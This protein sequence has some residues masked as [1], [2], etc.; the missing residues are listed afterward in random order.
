[1][2]DSHSTSRTSCGTTNGPQPDVCCSTSQ[3]RLVQEAPPG[4]LVHRPSGSVSQSD[5]Q[6]R[7]WLPSGSLQLPSMSTMQGG[8]QSP[9][10]GGS[11]GH[12]GT[13]TSGALVEQAPPS[14]LP[15]NCFSPRRY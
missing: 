4:V 5:G 9:V 13:Q 8:R 15:L 12:S 1:R 10:G 11:S 6:T 2:P 14:A 3:E 7:H